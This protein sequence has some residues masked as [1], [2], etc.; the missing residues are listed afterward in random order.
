VVL[1][2]PDAIVETLRGYQ[3]EIDRL[4]RGREAIVRRRVL[5]ALRRAPLGLGSW[6]EDTRRHGG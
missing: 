4:V 6:P 5:S 3:R 2:L 1:S